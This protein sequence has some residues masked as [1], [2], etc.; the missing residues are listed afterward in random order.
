[1]SGRL[2]VAVVTTILDEAAVIFLLVWGLPILGVKLPIGVLVLIGVL[3]TSFAVT[4][5]F[6]GIKILRKKPLAGQTDMTGF[7]GKVVRDLSTQGMVKIGGEIWTARSASG[8]IRKNEEIIV[9][10]QNGL[11]LIVRRANK[12]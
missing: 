8:I 4:L 12:L 5:Y 10:S 6:S 3:W 9:E 2:I 11:T 1:M 7:R